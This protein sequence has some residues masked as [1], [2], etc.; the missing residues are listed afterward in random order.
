MTTVSYDCPVCGG[1]VLSGVY[2]QDNIP[3][4]S[5]LLVRDKVDAQ[6]FPC[7]NLK[8]DCCK[9]CGFGFN[10]IFDQ[11]PMN[12]SEDYEET[13]G[14]SPTFSQH[15]QRMAKN[16][17]DRFK[18]VN[19]RIVEIGCGKGEFLSLLCRGGG[20]HGL[21]FD[22]A[23][24]PDRLTLP[25]N[26][27]IKRSFFDA[28]QQLDSVDFICCM[29]TLEHISDPLT[30]LKDLRN[31]IGDQKPV[32]L[33]QVPDAQRIYNRG[34]FWD[35][36]YEHCNYFTAAALSLAFVK[37]GFVVEEIVSS[38]AEQYLTLVAYPAES[39]VGLTQLENSPHNEY[40]GF[41][42]KVSE[43]KNWLRTT[44]KDNHN[45]GG[46]LALWGGGSKAVALL[47]AL[48]LNENQCR[49]VDINHHKIGNYLPKTSHKVY[50]PNSLRQYSPDIVIIMNSAYR[51]EISVQLQE[52]G[53]NSKLIALP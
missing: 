16:L 20:N 43:M 25:E 17:V 45:N 14:F 18:L 36:Y 19:S 48:E 13:Q 10:S 1:I 12:Y 33:F 23:F 26:V 44:I 51:S 5:V 42:S 11:A 40:C 8:I 50:D 27:H 24:V 29:M 31:A 2:T 32:V 6:N 21:G 34:A 49:V 47:T 39:S 9:N 22:P 52:M 46:R 28:N 53:L 4:H 15:Q 30:F 7:A 37:S 41:S 35:M 3:V 38:F